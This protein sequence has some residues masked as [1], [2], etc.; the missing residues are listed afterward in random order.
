MND[1]STLTL[2]LI[3][4]ILLGTFFFGGLWWTVRKGIVSQHPVIWFFI[5]LMIRMGATLAG[6]Y[7]IARDHWERAIIC[8]IGFLIAR[9]IITWLTRTSSAN[10]VH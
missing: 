4:G 1:L 9:A 6:F 8:L 7:F 2:V 10:P 5:S 3:A